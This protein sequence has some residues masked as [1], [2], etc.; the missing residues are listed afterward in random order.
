M[1]ADTP[2]GL[3]VIG[4]ALTV[5]HGTDDVLVLGVKPFHNM[6]NID[7]MQFL[8]AKISMAGDNRRCGSTG[9]GSGQGGI[10]DNYYGNI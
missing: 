10:N 8:K 6:L 5:I 9:W 4:A 1:P 2:S 3:V 7:T